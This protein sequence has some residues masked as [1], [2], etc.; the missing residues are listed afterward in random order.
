MAQKTKNIISVISTCFVLLFLFAVLNRTGSLTIIWKEFALEG[1]Q[2]D[3]GH[4]YYAFVRDENISRFSLPFYLKEDETILSRDPVSVNEDVTASIKSEGGG[5]YQLQRNNDLYFSAADNEPEKHAYQI[6]SPVIIR[7][8]YLLAIFALT[9]FVL[10][11]D[12]FLSL[13]YKDRDIFRTILRGTAAACMILLLLPWDQMVFSGAPAWF[14]PTLIKPVLQRNSIFLLLLFL[15]VAAAFRFFKKDRFLP[16]LSVLVILTNTVYYFVPEWDYY[17]RRA[18]SGAY[19]QHYSASSIRTPGYP[20]FIETVYRITGNPG[21]EP[22]RSE[23][24]DLPDEVLRSCRI[25]DSRGL[26]DVVRAQ[27]CVLAVLFLEFFVVFCRYYSIFWFVFGAQIILCRGFLGVDNSYIMTECLS[28]GFILLCAAMFLMTVKEKKAVWFW[29]LCAAAGI[30]ILIRPANIFLAI[31]L[32]VGAV[33]LILAGRSILIPLVGGLVFLCISAI[34]AVTIFRQYGIFVWMPTSGYVEIARAVDLMQPG[35]E[36]AFDD[37]ELRD[38][39]L[40]LLEKKKELPDA[41]Q[42]TYMWDAGVAAAEARGYDRI[43]CSPLFVKV[44][45]KIFTIR[46]REFTASLFGTIKTALDRTRLR[47][48]D[49]GFPVLAVLFLLLSLIKPGED[50]LTGLLFMLSHAAHLCISMMNQPERRYIY[51]TEI[52]CLLGWLLILI[53]LADTENYRKPRE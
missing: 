10:A 30:G 49:L 38:F 32:A 51:S 16:I 50:S 26:V 21:L 5:R 53:R 37:P 34:P 52:L 46:F 14:G 41:D 13:K 2:H 44:S 40:D 45:R 31:L 29:L 39:C 12:L 9:A 36:Q 47:V 15:L 42:N 35:D 27:K 18:D 25:E 11:A 6:I 48:G 20:V 1:I 23:T 8:R 28:Q 22:I 4:G 43:S 17:G 24:D 33:V 19:L 7:N 3:S